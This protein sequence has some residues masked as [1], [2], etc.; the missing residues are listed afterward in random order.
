MRQQLGNH[1]IQQLA[2]TARNLRSSFRQ[3]SSSFR[4]ATSNHAMSSSFRENNDDEV[5][6]QWAAIQRLPS[7]KRLRTSLL[8][9]RLLVD[10]TSKEEDDIKT[11]RKR[12]L[13]DV[14]ELRA[15]EHHV[16]IEKLITKIEDDNLRLLKKLKEKIDRVGLQLST[17]EVRFQNLSVE[18]DCEVVQGMPI[19]TLWT[20]I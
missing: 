4:N 3:L 6:L 9:H 8:D 2:E 5:A 11:H 13:V 7:F 10:D 18:A 17:I 15:M 12:M 1:E 16:F 19:P 14:T 20:I